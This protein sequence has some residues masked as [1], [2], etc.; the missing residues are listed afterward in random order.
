MQCINEF[1]RNLDIQDILSLAQHVRGL[2]QDV[3]AFLRKST[4]AREDNLSY[5]RSLQSTG[6]RI[7]TLFMDAR[8][9]ESRQLSYLRRKDKALQR[10]LQMLKSFFDVKK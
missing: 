7:E 6:T 8:N 3:R 10:I 4:A 2:E 5:R 1:R 9:E